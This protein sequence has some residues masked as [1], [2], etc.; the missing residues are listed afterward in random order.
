MHLG[1]KSIFHL[2]AFAARFMCTLSFI[3]DS[4]SLPI[5]LFKQRQFEKF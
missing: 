1:S 3:Y 4:H 2:E 5:V